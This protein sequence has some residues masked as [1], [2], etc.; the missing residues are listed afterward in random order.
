ML[1]YKIKE[2]PLNRNY[3]L[4]NP[5][6]DSLRQFMLNLLLEEKNN[7][8]FQFLKMFTTD[9]F[10]EKRHSKFDGA[11]HFLFQIFLKSSFLFFKGKYIFSIAFGQLIKFYKNCIKP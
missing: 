8:L 10:H 6:S 2:M 4:C 11:Q 9:S 1:K 5:L 7:F 3:T